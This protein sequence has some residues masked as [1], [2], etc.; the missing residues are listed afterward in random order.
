MKH[1]KFGCISGALLFGL[2][3]TNVGAVVIYNWYDV[4]PNS[5][6]GPIKASIAFDE[7]IWTYGGAFTHRT[8]HSSDPAPYFGVES[9]DFAT[10]VNFDSTP[11][12][13]RGFTDPIQLRSS[14]C[15][16]SPGYGLSPYCGARGLL[17]ND[18]VVSPGY[19]NFDVTFG[20]F[21]TGSMYLNDMYTDVGMSS[22]D[23]L[24]TIASLGSDSPGA[25]YHPANCVGGTGYWKLLKIDEPSTLL[26]LMVGFLSLAIAQ[27][28]RVAKRNAIDVRVW[29]RAE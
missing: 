17:A 24:F 21:L 5:N 11:S 15:G 2:L 29:Q 1:F 18:I 22:R 3:T 8:A 27:Q 19:W 13:D 20:E 12:V 6:V 25:C 4:A 9:I 14:E 23:S 16:H 26:L 10:P 28:R 7:S